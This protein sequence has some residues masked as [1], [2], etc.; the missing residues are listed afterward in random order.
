[1]CPAH[2]LVGVKGSTPT[3]RLLESL[4]AQA[5]L[6]HV[7]QGGLED[8][9][10]AVRERKPAM[11][12]LDPALVSTI[13][14]KHELDETLSRYEI[15]CFLIST[16][17]PLPRFPSAPNGQGDGLTLETCPT[18]FDQYAPDAYFAL[19]SIANAMPIVIWALDRN[20][21]F[22]L[23]EGQ[24]LGALG[25]KQGQVVGRSVF[26]LYADYP[27]IVRDARRA[28]QGETFTSV[29]WIERLVFE[30]HYVPL[31][32][33]DGQPAGA[34]GVAMDISDLHAAID[35][36]LAKETHFQAVFENA[37]VGI[38]RSA[39]DGKVLE[40][41]RRFL[42]MLGYG[43]LE[44]M[45]GMTV[46]DLTY[47][48][49]ARAEELLRETLLEGRQNSYAMEKR[50]IRRD[51]T[52]L[53]AS[54][55][56]AAV[57]S[58][59]GE[60]L[61]TIGVA[62]DITARKNAELA[63]ERETHFL[64]QVLNTVAS[65]VVVMNTDG[66]I[67]GFNRACENLSGYRFEEVQGRCVWD[68]LLPPAV[69]PQVKGVFARLQAGSFPSRFENVWITRDGQQ[70]LI[71]WANSAILDAGGQVDYVI[72][73]GIDVTEQRRAEALLE[74]RRLQQDAILNNIPDLAWLKDGQ[75]RYLAVNE[76]FAR[77]AGY[78]P[79]QL[80]G[81]TDA[82]IWPEELA[83][84][85]R[86][87]DRE[88][89]ETRQRKRSEDQVWDSTG[90][91][92]WI[93]TIRTPV[94]DDTGAVVGTTG[95][96]RDI[97]QQKQDDDRIR[98]LATHDLLTLLPNRLLFMETL[99]L[100]LARAR[101][102]AQRLAVLFLDLDQ[103]KLINDTLGHFSGDAL[104]KVVAGR[105]RACLRDTDVV[106]RFG[107]DEFALLLEDLTKPEEALWATGKV[108]EAVSA[109]YST[110]R[111]HELVVTPSIGISI[112]PDDGEDAETLLKHADVAMYRAKADG[113][114]AY[115]FFSTEMSVESLEGLVLKSSLRQALGKGEFLLHY[116]PRIDLASRRIL[117]V[118]ALLRWV[119]PE[120][121]VVSPDRFIPAAEES[122]LILPIGQWV[123]RAACSQAVSWIQAGLPPIRMAVN[124]S[125]RQFR[126]RVLT[127]LIES[128]LEETGL[129][130]D[131]LE[132][133]VTETSVMTDADAA[134]RTLETVSALGC[135]VSIDDF[136]TGYSSLNYLK[137][138]P[139][140][141]IKIDRSFV[142]D[143]PK[144]GNDAAIARAVIQLGH[145]LGLKVVAEG[146]EQEAQLEFLEAAGCDEVQ[147]YLFARPLPADEVSQLLAG[148]NLD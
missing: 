97:T 124:L 32:D 122:G 67:V 132:L 5:T 11:A 113:R 90:V 107:G 34:M 57:H 48:E 91:L 117:G 61:Y 136:G 84:K 66:Q 75:G 89:M 140:D 55:N 98:F 51:G 105:I 96:A 40:I 62:Q 108:I 100:A 106:A 22:T 85:Y 13:D 45:G 46:T 52:I 3:C 127:S 118:E 80:V 79:E 68:F 69:V 146:V 101:R 111:G 44:E 12:L 25:L 16:I 36:L 17:V 59:D 143:L 82:D 139:I 77:S 99:E 18:T 115:R 95:L 53:W 7:L 78:T 6:V 125:A 47:P 50:Y 31:R 33:A 20:G 63:L 142:Q 121:G 138:F 93:D 8:F 104:L 60:S 88:V 24:G 135:H 114:N 116:Q 28:L 144:D 109:P 119:H 15:P 87:D 30:S 65:L 29:H 76:A 19:K 83:E 58:P 112:F 141:S 27:D 86:Q 129:P 1:M 74:Q 42:E 10:S 26:E 73:T 35:A 133:E 123:L 37:A 81:Q 120:M 145:A 71:A 2:I 94:F 147:G 128:I 110:A 137:R 126:D 43:A 39:P 41:N 92:R 54:V 148:G 70:R 131:L 103:F 130:A 4:S 21:I 9:L 134:V 38:A 102:N 64:E 14:E 56:V 49:D 72:A 23:S